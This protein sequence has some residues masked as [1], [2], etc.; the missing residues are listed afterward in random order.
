M[1]RLFRKTATL[2]PALLLLSHFPNVSYAQKA[3]THVL[4]MDE[5]KMVKR[6]AGT[7][8]AAGDYN[9]ALK[10]YKDLVK[11]DAKNVDYNYKLGYCY[12]QTNTD[13]KASL[14]YLE[15][16]TKAKE[17][18]KEWMFYLGQAYMF[19][20]KWDDAIAA[21]NDFKDSKQKPIKDQPAVERMIEYCNNAKEL[22]AKPINCT[23]T[24]LGKVINTVYEEYNPFISADG[25][26]LV[27]TSRRKGNVGGFIEDLGIYTADIY[28]TIWKD[29]IWAKPKGLGGMVNTEWDEE[30]VGLSPDG[31][32]ILIYFDNG[33]SY[34]DIGG[35]SLKGKMWQKPMMMPEQ[36][37]SKN[38]EGG[39]TMSLD[40]RTVIFSSTKKEGYGETD[41]YMVHKEKNGEWTAPVNLGTNINTKYAEESPCLS[42]DGKTLFFASKGWNSMGGFDIFYSTYDDASNS[43]S[44]PVNFGYP[45]N[46][47]DD[48]QFISFTGDMRSA[49]VAAIRPEGLGDQDIYKVDFPDE[50]HHSYKSFMTGS[51]TSTGGKIELTKASLENKTNGSSIEYIPSISNNSFIF[52]ANPGTYNLHIEGYNFEPYNEEVIIE[53]GPAKEIVHNVQVKSAK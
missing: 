19:N 10:A 39:A 5:A 47:A 28:T 36:V 4:T 15:F 1:T 25:K 18:K 17:A 14:S 44:K 40:G 34:A 13:K 29:T 43:W 35:S 27:F 37:N 53:A 16:A 7:M 42:I 2:L 6:D 3:K 23:Y 21:F 32:L 50:S 8:F 22:T 38:Y 45:I 24:N 9:G 51:L 46:D 31:D 33:E 48:N 30:S 11:S 20:E 49:Y 12:L 52:P 41:L 26:L